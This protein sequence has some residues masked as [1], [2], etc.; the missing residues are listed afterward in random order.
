MFH[1][2]KHKKKTSNIFSTENICSIGKVFLSVVHQ[3]NIKTG[4]TRRIWI[5]FWKSSTP[6]YEITS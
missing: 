1:L 5:T 6:W 2:P 3:F 4:V